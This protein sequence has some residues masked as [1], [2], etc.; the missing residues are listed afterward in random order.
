MPTYVLIHGSGSSSWYRHLLV[1]E[2]RE[3]GHD[4][5]AVDLPTDDDS[6]GLTEYVDAAV[7]AIGDRRDPQ[8]DLAALF[9]HGFPRE[10][11]ARGLR[12]ASPRPRS[13]SR[14]HS[15]HGRE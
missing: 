15:R 11:L 5:V 14:G 10:V 3:R 9:F 1:P 12:V 6:A 8:E 2:L 13:S 4:V 7:E